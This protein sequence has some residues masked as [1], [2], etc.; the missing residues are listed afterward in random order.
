MKRLAVEIHTGKADKILRRMKVDLRIADATEG[1]GTLA[2]DLPLTGGQR[3]PGH[4][5]AER[6]E[7]V[8]RPRRAAAAASASRSAARRR[9]GAG[10]AGPGPANLRKYSRCVTEADGNAAATRK[11]ADLL[12]P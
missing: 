11:C 8:R 9:A 10:A 5:R 4:P 7:A 6:R 3:G 1:S 2:L 12:A